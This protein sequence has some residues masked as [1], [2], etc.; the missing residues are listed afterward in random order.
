MVH[1]LALPGAPSFGGSIDAVIAAALTDARSL[2]G[3]GCAALLFE[4][5]GDRP[6]HK[7]PPKETIAAMTRVIADVVRDVRCTFGLNVLRNDPLGALAI[8]AA[9]GASF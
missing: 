8:A 1:L 7:S 9:T 5:F 2:I 4:N 3:G 6:F